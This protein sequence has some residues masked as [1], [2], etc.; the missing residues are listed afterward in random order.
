MTGT[1]RQQAGSYKKTNLPLVGDKPA[2]DFWLACR[3]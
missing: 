1:I 2:S 3:E